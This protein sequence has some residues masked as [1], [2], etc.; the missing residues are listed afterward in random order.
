LI[1]WYIDLDPAL[2]EADVSFDSR[3]CEHLKSPLDHIS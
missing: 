3:F 1:E 2:K